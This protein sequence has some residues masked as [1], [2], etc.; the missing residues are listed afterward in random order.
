MSA[1]YIKADKLASVVKGIGALVKKQVLVGIP[2]ST[3]TRDDDEKP[4]EMNNATLGYIH[5][6]GSPAANIPARP[7]LMPGVEDAQEDIEARLKKAADAA[8]DGKP[9]RVDQQ[10]EAA[11]ITAQNSVK[12]K[13]NS[14]DFAPLS[15]ATLRARARRGRQGAIDE[16]QSRAA[17]NAPNNDNARPL[18]DTGQLRNAITYVVR[19]K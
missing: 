19:G 18:I 16:L 3:A 9:G 4:G 6:F 2:D 11:G 13:I 15:A 5:E 17:G 10:L 14:G 12:D 8:L 1:T 7:F